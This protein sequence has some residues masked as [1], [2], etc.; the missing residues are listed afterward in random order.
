[1]GA[2]LNRIDNAPGLFV[3]RCP[4]CD[5]NH[6]V[7]VDAA[8]YKNGGGPVWGWNGSV[9]KPTFTP[10]L[11]VKSGHFVDTPIA[12]SGVQKSCWCTWNA[13]HPDDPAPFKCNQCHSFIREGM[14][15]FL[16]DCSHALAGKTVELPDWISWQGK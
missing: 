12:G 8:Y 9:E 15:E 10:S 2:K 3:F 6:Q 4:G 1:M 7:V 16:G 5:D 14:I 13:A 11:L